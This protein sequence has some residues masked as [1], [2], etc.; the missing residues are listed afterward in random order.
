MQ[1]LMHIGKSKQRDSDSYGA[2][3]CHSDVELPPNGILKC[4]LR[5]AKRQWWKWPEAGRY[6]YVQ[7]KLGE[8]EEKT[9]RT[10]K[11]GMGGS[12]LVEE[13]DTRVREVNRSI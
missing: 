11:L 1:I 12:R 6:K 10:G 4:V 2:V 9:A 3:F 13:H 7:P 5:K 8:K